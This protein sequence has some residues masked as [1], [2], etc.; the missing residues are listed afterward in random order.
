MGTDFKGTEGE[1]LV[2][3][4]GALEY[5]IKAHLIDEIVEG[6]VESW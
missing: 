5:K 6:D 2:F 1:Y 4:F 3:A